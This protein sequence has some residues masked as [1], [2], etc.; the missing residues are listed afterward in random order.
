MAGALASLLPW[1][2]Q[3]ELAHVAIVATSA[4]LF[5]LRGIGRVAGAR[6][7]LAPPLRRASICIDTLLLAAGL[8]LWTMLGLDPLRQTWLGAKLLL[9]PVYIALGSL[10]IGGARSST[11]RAAFL[12]AALAVLALM[13]SIAIG[14]R[15]FGFLQLAGMR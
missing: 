1:Y 7:P 2:A 3:L 4:S 9:L 14:H 15:P 5:T 8:L 12:V 11:A 10:A 13:A 6:W